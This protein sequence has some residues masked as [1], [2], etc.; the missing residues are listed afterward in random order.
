MA[1]RGDAMR[2]AFDKTI[3]ARLQFSDFR[4]LAAVSF[5]ADDPG[6]LSAALRHVIASLPDPT[7]EQLVQ[8]EQLRAPEYFGN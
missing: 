7:P 5:K 8:I 2:K 3:Q 4:K 6:N 1:Q